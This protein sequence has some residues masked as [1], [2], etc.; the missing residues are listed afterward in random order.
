MTSTFTLD[1]IVMVWKRVWVTPLLPDFCKGI[2]GKWYKVYFDNFV[3]SYPLLEYLY[4]NK[5]LACGTVRQRRKGFPAVLYDKDKTKA[6]KR[7]EAI[8][9]MNGPFIAL[10]WLDKKPVTISGTITGIP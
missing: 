1:V 2:E 3:T 7:G 8:W 9:R 10:M 4:C 6:M 5:I